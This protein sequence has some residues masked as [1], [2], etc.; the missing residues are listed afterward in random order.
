MLT[1]YLDSLDLLQV[2]T[3][4]HQLLQPPT[5]PLAVAVVLAMA[6]AV[7]LTDHSAAVV[8]LTAPLVVAVAATPHLSP[9]RPLA[10]SKPLHRLPH[11]Q[12]KWL[13]RDRLHR[14]AVVHNIRSPAVLKR[15]TNL[16]VETRA[17]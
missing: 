3:Q 7:A 17:G 13:P 10:P 5:D 6:V 16:A 9:N 4:Q 14:R 15:A 8:A 11:R 12:Q 2:A 1:K